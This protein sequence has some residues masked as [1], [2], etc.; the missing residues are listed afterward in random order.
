MC[1]TIKDKKY[2][3]I[4]SYVCPHSYFVKIIILQEVKLPFLM[5]SSEKAAFLAFKV[6][7]F[8]REGDPKFDLTS[9]DGDSAVP[10]W[11]WT[12][13]LSR[14]HP[15]ICHHPHLKDERQTQE[16][17]ETDG[18]I[19]GSGRRWRRWWRKEEKR[20]QRVSQSAFILT[21]ASR[22]TSSHPWQTSTAKHQREKGQP[23]AMG[24]H[25]GA[26]LSSIPLYTHTSKRYSHSHSTCPLDLTI[27]T[28]EQISR[29]VTAA[30]KQMT[31]NTWLL[32][33]LFLQ[34]GMRGAAAAGF[35]IPLVQ[36][37]SILEMWFPTVHVILGFG[38]SVW[39][40]QSLQ[41]TGGM[42]TTATSTN[43]V[44]CIRED[45]LNVSDDV[46]K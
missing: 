15:Q 42:S 22:C 7:K 11:R 21:W 18:E 43:N 26:K 20:S 31:P 1:F 45:R 38:R 36:I 5:I 29:L 25:H 4:I 44:C 24:S 8:L 19:S 9:A 13:P 35:G 17:G 2:V 33:G 37:Y 34:G 41:A 12:V 10:E 3:I 40:A 46:Q 6:T 23:G 16:D 30:Q 14:L 32:Y 28:Q 27:K 39:V